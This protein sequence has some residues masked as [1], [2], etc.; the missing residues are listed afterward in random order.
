MVNYKQSNNPLN[1]SKVFIIGHQLRQTIENPRESERKQSRM[2]TWLKKTQ[3]HIN[4]SNESKKLNARTKNKMIGCVQF[5]AHSV[6]S[7]QGGDMSK[8]MY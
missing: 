6:W 7:A 3:C 1:H 2:G 8:N 5:W 4:T